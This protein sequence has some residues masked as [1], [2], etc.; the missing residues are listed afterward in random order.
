MYIMTGST[1]SRHSVADNYDAHAR[2]AVNAEDALSYS[3]LFQRIHEDL[4]IIVEDPV[5]YNNELM[6]S[7]IYILPGDMVTAGDMYLC[8]DDIILNVLSYVYPD[9]IIHV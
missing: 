3:V 4:D 2:D 1:L 9:D 8:I 7:P 6:N 5:L